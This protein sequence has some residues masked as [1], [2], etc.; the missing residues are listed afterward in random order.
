MCVLVYETLACVC[1]HVCLLADN[2]AVCGLVFT[3]LTRPR[4]EPMEAPYH[5]PSKPHVP[6]L[7]P[8]AEK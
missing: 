8:P 5:G 6:Q 4:V 3:Y 2:H 1:L 7:K